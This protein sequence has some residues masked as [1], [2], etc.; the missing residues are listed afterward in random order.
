MRKEID[1]LLRAVKRNCAVVAKNSNLLWSLEELEAAR[2]SGQYQSEDS[3]LSPDSHAEV[4]GVYP[5]C[6]HGGPV[7][8]SLSYRAVGQTGHFIIFAPDPPQ[9]MMDDQRERQRSENPQPS[10]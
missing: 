5:G 2:D 8:S 9:E 4:S 3:L 10:E 6:M 7:L 1:I